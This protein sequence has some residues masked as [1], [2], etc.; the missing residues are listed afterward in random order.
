MEINKAFGAVLTAGI[1]F[2][3]ASLI[4]STIIHPHKLEKPA[5]AIEGAAAPATAAAPAED[6]PI[7]VLLAAA[8]PARG[9]ARSR[10]ASPATASTRA[11][12]RALARIFMVS[13][14]PPMAIW[15]GMPTPPR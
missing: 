15:K 8:D 1:A 11:A 7:A 10:A 14:V 13:S 2:M 12:K 4:G 5:I 3:G 6:P 9:Q